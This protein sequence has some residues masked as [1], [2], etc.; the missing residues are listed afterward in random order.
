MSAFGRKRP[1]RIKLFQCFERPL[2]SKAD[3]QIL[4]FQ[5]SL[6]SGRMIPIAAGELI[7]WR[8]A[9]GDPFRSPVELPIVQP[10]DIHEHDLT[11]PE[12]Q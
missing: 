8:Q 1:V 11:K 3:I 10:I 6:L 5:N 7:G 12:V 9:G 2:W 4:V